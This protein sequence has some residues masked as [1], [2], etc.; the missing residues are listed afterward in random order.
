VY[1]PVPH[2]DQVVVF[3]LAAQEFSQVGNGAFMTKSLAVSP[4]V[5][6]DFRS[7]RVFGNESRRSVEALDLPAELK[8]DLIRA[9]DEY[10]EFDA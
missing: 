5:R 4:F 9:F 10:R 3:T 2:G 8:F 1:D 7:S 6:T